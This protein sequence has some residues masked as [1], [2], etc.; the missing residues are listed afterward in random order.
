MTGFPSVLS[1]T[2]LTLC[3]AEGGAFYEAIAYGEEGLRIAEAVDDPFSLVNAYNSI[4]AVYLRQGAL[5]QAIALLA[6]GLALC[7]TLGYP[8]LAPLGRREVGP[9]LCPV[10]ARRG[11]SAV[12]RT[13]CLEGQEGWPCDVYRPSER[14]V[15]PGWPH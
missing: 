10:R 2:C 8:V 13:G 11:G 12:T 3:L 15:S 14:G 6:R 7:Q 1:R 9:C 5:S 4:G